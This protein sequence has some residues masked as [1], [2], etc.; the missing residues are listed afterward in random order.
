MKGAIRGALSLLGI[1]G[2]VGLVLWAWAFLATIR[3]DARYARE[4]FD[5]VVPYQRVLASR[6]HHTTIFGGEG[7]GCTYAVVVLADAAPSDPP[8]PSRV[9]DGMWAFGGTGSRPRTMGSLIR[10]GTALGGCARSLSA[11]SS[12]LTSPRL[13]P[14]RWAG[15][16]RLRSMDR[17]Y[18]P[19]AKVS[20]RS[21]VWATESVGAQE[22]P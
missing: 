8:A 7:F 14:N 18:T 4:V 3:T 21:S 10:P 20:R 19:R 17:R 12:G 9:H 13:Q 6:R 11:R 5:G 15:R 1:V 22:V 2:V 16:L